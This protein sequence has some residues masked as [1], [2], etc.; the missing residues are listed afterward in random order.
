[1]NN[2][3]NSEVGIFY[4]HFIRKSCTVAYFSCKYIMPTF[5]STEG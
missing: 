3:K 4:D 5:H 2:V 1:M